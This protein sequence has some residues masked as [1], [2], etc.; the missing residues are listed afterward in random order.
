[1]DSMEHAAPAGA[2]GKMGDGVENGEE[3]L[4]EGGLGIIVAVGV[5]RPVDEEGAAHDGFAV[6]KAPV[7][8]VGAVVAVIAHGE[9]LAGRYDELVALNVV[10][11]FAGPLDLYGRNE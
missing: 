2:R 9:I 5:H 6:D 3:A 11:D 1:M 10:S 4:A 7:A 8:A